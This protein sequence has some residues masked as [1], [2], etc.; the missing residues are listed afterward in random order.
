MESF[1]QANTSLST[2]RDGLSQLQ[3][4]V[5]QLQTGANSLNNGLVTGPEGSQKVS[6]NTAKLMMVFCKLMTVRSSYLM[7]LLFN[8]SI[9]E[10]AISLSDSTRWVGS[11]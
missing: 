4:G 2:V 3:S 7:D 8:W 1:K 6:D 11:N 5:E 9:G 10:L